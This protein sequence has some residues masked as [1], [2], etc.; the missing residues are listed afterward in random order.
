MKINVNNCGNHDSLVLR[1][2]PS[3]IAQYQHAHIETKMGDISLPARVDLVLVLPTLLIHHDPELWGDDAE[4]FKSE[5]F[6]V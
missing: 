5:R 1:L 3:V 2:Y 4:E 6:S